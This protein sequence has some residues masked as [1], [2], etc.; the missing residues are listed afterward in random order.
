M[1]TI[2][3]TK[4][5][6][7]STFNERKAFDET[8]AGVKG[9]VDAGVEK[10][11]SLFHHQPDKYEI[12]NNTSNVIPVIDLDDID[13]KDPSIHQGI[14]EKVKEACETLGFFQVVNHGIPLS[15]LEELNDGVKRFYEQDTEA[16]KSFYTRDMQRSFIYNSNVDIYSSP[17]L[18]WKDSFG[19]NLA[20]PDTLK[21]EE[22]PVVCR[23]ILL[24]YGKHMMNLGTLLFELLSE[25]LGLNPNHL[26]DMDCAEGLIALCHYY[27]PCPEPEL[28]VGT[29]KHSDNDFLTVLLQDH[30]GG[31]Q[32]LYDDKWIDI[33]PVSGALIVNVG[34]LL[35]L[36]T[37][38]KFKS[39]VHRVLANTVGPRIS[40]ACFFSTGL[41]ASS[42]LY[43]PM[44][45]LL[46]EDNPPKYKETTVAD[47][48]AYYF[49]AKGVDG[50]SALE[51]Y[52]I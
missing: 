43:G 32:V 17:A 26:K 4:P 27:P 21:P 9:L 29:T 42:K 1:G 35:Q 40:V 19:C 12:A 44:K 28:T 11:P 2:D 33:T 50:T 8:K 22:F 46:S 3:T 14:V 38:D 25:A 49:R 36:I 45:E 16:K 31:L 41:K 39:V 52:K 48:V 7:D 15:V 34:D 23:D 37:N 6:L 24:R 5:N 30:I 10:I 47:Y 13:N 20:P 18:N 51:H